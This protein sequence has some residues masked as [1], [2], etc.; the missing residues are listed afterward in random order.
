MK[1]LR[2]TLHPEVRVLDAA[3]GLVEYVASDETIDFY[4]EVVRASGWRF[5]HFQKNS[6]FVDSHDYRSVERCL[7]AVVDYKV[8]DGKLIETVKWAKDVPENTLAQL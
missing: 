2:R 3:A 1:H 5:T 8:R 7:G 4:K 6:P